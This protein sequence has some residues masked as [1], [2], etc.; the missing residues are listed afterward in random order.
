MGKKPGRSR[1]NQRGVKKGDRKKKYDEDDHVSP[2]LPYLKY[3]REELRNKFLFF[4][5]WQELSTAEA[6]ELLNVLLEKGTTLHYSSVAAA[7]G[8]SLCSCLKCSRKDS[9]VAKSTPSAH[10]P[11][12]KSAAD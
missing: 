4:G 12:K 10:G 11:I 5:G 7:V 1:V 8:F 2:I 3:A 6:H 9:T